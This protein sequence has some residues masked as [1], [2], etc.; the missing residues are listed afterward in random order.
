M[1]YVYLIK[2]W[3]RLWGLAHEKQH[4]S[5]CGSKRFYFPFFEI[6]LSS[7]MCS[8]FSLTLTLVLFCLDPA[9]S[10]HFI[11]M[12]RMIVF[13]SSG[14]MQATLTT[15]CRRRRQSSMSTRSWRSRLVH[16]PHRS[17]TSRQSNRSWWGISAV[18]RHPAPLYSRVH[19]VIVAHPPQPL[20]VAAAAFVCMVCCCYRS[21]YSCAVVV[22]E[23]QQQ[24]HWSFTWCFNFTD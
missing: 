13:F 4:Q 15:S 12:T 18:T 1:V 10:L 9:L 16:C 21:C 20:A 8:N 24:Q 2:I 19:H 11:T 5:N 6:S 14:L 7:W 17:E 3:R 23:L 22:L